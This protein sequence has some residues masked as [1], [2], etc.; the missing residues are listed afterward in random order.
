MLRKAISLLLA[1]SILGAG[2]WLLHLQIFVWHSTIG[3]V[4]LI[5]G[6]LILLGVGWLVGDFILPLFPNLPTFSNAWMHCSPEV[7]PLGVGFK[8]AKA[9][10]GLFSERSCSSRDLEFSRRVRLLDIPGLYLAQGRGV[11]AYS[12]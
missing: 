11:D 12:S 8:K 5:S 2:L 3:L 1:C 9:A 10:I 7:M 4:A 6:F